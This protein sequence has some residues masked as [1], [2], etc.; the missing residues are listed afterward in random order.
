MKP[1]PEPPAPSAAAA[2]LS[3]S[4]MSSVFLVFS[5][6]LP[7]PGCHKPLCAE[8]A[9]PGT[10]FSP[11]WISRWEK[12]SQ[13]TPEGPARAGNPLPSPPS[14]VMVLVA[15]LGVK[16]KKT[17]GNFPLFHRIFASVAVKVASLS[18]SGQDQTE[19]IQFFGLF[20]SAPCAE[21][22]LLQ[23]Q[24]SC[25]MVRSRINGWTLPLSTLMTPSCHHHFQRDGPGPKNSCSYPEQP[26]GTE[27]WRNV[28]LRVKK[29][30]KIII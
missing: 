9:Q 1:P 12:P 15:W 29:N 5:L 3:L 18:H 4:W 2:A 6:S 14:D 20:P 13:P 28:W 17:P 7:S 23:A 27:L 10:G 11:P 21:T 26:L 24:L 25:G 30:F 16:R 19:I 22:S 8:L